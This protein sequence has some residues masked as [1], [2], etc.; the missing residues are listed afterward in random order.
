M[1]KSWYHRQ[2]SISRREWLRL[3]AASS[4]MGPLFSFSGNPANAQP[5]PGAGV[6]KFSA[7]S[8]LKITDIRACLVAAKCID[9]RGERV[10]TQRA[11]LL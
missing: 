1:D 8:G 9:Q 10:R 6:N 11:A 3:A 5:K 4:A 2:R 7:P